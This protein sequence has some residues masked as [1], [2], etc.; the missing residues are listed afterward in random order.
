MAGVPRALYRVLVDNDEDH[1]CGDL[2]EDACREVPTNATKLVG[3]LTL[4]KLGDSVVDPK[5]VLAWLLV[6]LGSSTGLVAMLV[7]VREAGS[8]LPQAAMVPFVRR[9]IRRKWA[10]VAASFAQA[11]AVLSMAWAA[12]NLSG[13]PA[14]WTILL[15]LAVFATAR[16]VASIASKDVLAKT[17]PQGRRGAINGISASVAG[18]G[19][20]AIGVVIALTG[21]T[22]D[23]TPT[24]AWLLVGGAAAWLLGAVMFSSIEEPPGEH[25]AS[26]DVGSIGRALSLLASDRAFRRFVFV[27]ALLLVTALSSPFVVSMAVGVEGG[28]AGLGPFVVASGAAAL[29]GSPVWGRLADRSSRAVM[30]GAAAAGAV[31]V[32]VF[33]A[34]TA[35]T[36]LAASAWLYVGAHSALALAHAGARIGRKTYVVDLAEGNKRTDYVA[37]SNT[38]MGFVLLATGGLGALAATVGPQLALGMLALMGATGALLA[39]TLPEVGETDRFSV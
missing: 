30:A 39:R 32:V 16:S 19:A 24:L 21:R 33:L 12:A 2:P 18:A 37:V 5:T 29:V 7:P 3:S 36:L 25:D 13:R 26:V 11:L 14:G 23:P 6:G 27:R 35:F 4:T 22:D 10:W 8:L 31:V 28:S 9:L 1:G 15:A 38:A 20:I 17:V 34:A